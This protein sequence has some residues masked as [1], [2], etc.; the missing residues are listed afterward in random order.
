MTLP[1]DY[2]NSINF[3]KNNMMRDTDNDELAEQSYVPFLTNRSLSYFP[4]TIFYANQINE[5]HHVDYKLQYEYLLNSIRPKKRFAKWAK[6][7][8]S[9]DLEMVK[10]YYGYSNKKAEQA[11]K[12]LS[13]AE[14]A[15]I[16]AVI[17]RGI[18]DER[19]VD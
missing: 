19:G 14:I 1:F 10:M 8:D 12:L 13:P 18:T 11:L 16:R 9:N 2:V 4:D 17:T 3:K 5:D 15:N 7:V 6:A